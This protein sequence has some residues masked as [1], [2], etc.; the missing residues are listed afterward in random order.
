MLFQDPLAW[1]NILLCS[2]QPLSLRRDGEVFET[3]RH[4]FA[5][6]LALTFFTLCTSPAAVVNASPV[7]SVAVGLA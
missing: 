5:S 7:L 3:K 6:A 1:P 4:S 2:P